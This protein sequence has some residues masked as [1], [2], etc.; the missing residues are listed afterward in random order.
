MLGFA[1]ALARSREREGGGEGK[2]EDGAASERLLARDDEVGQLAR[3][4]LYFSEAARPAG[5]G[6]GAIPA[7]SE[8]SERAGFDGGAGAADAPAGSGS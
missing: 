6:G 8:S 4:F 1:A 7:R 5:R 3:L 2:A